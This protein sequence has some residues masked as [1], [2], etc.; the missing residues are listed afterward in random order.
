MTFTFFGIVLSYYP[1]M[2]YAVTSGVNTSGK[3]YEFDEK[4][5]YEFSSTEE[6]T[7]TADEGKTYGK[8]SINANITDITE[9]NGIASYGVESEDV[10]ISYTY[11]DSLLTAGEDEWHLIDD[12]SKFV[13]VIKL[14]DKIMKGVLILQTS[15][16]GKTWVDDV[17]KTNVFEEIP[18]QTESFY[19]A[20]DVQLVNGCY[21]RV[22][23]AYETR[24]KSDPT[25]VLFV[26]LDNYENKKQAEVYEFYVYSKNKALDSLKESENKLKYSLGSKVNTGKGNGYSGSNGI[27]KKDPHYGWELGNFF[28]SGYT[29]NTKDENGNLVFLKM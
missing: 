15:T 3:I 11:G 2:I 14:D 25:K 27:E 10:T 19:S 22:I 21:Y 4:S 26:S 13:D 12:K 8:L 9:I 17:C 23:V 18:T 29:R 1:I 28:I 24:I 16:D 5:H 6:Y 7:S 20:T